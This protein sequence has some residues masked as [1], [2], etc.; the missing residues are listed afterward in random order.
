MNKGE[1][2]ETAA[3]R[4]F[5]EEIGVEAIGAPRSLGEIRQ[6]SGK[7]VRAFALEGNIEASAVRSNTV[8]LEW[9]PRSG[10]TI[11]VPEI[12]RA[13][14]LDLPL[15]RRKILASQEPLLDRL[16]SV[17]APQSRSSRGT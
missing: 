12:D 9:P 6:R 17:A 11:R 4:E 8:V 7:I 13:A 3:R 16:E 14:W 15:A 1:D 5:T 2:A 10:H